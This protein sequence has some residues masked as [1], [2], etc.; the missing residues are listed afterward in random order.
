MPWTKLLADGY[1]LSKD[2]SAAG[3][4]KRKGRVLTYSAALREAL[5][6]ALKIDK[7]VFVMGEGV[8]DAGG[9]FGTTRGL[10]RLF[11][12]RRV[13][14]LPLAE[15]GFTGFA[16][17]AAITG[18]RP[19]IVHMRMDFML[20]SMDQIINHA[21]KW[22]YMFGGEQN[23]PLTI[24]C[25]IGRGWGSGAQHSQ[26]LEG[27]FMSIPGLKVVCPSNPYDA[28]GFLLSSISSNDP[29]IFVEHRWLYSHKGVVP[30]KPYLIPFG[31]GDILIKGKDITILTYSLMVNEALWAAQE[32]NNHGIKAEVIDL[33]S[34]RP[35]EKRLIIES[36][37]KTGRVII[38]ALD[39]ETGGVS[40]EIAAI[41]AEGAFSSLKNPIRR[42]AL[43]DTPTPGSHLLESAFYKVKTDIVKAAIQMCKSG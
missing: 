1:A 16:V 8:D 10:H 6:Q 39:W 42:I 23:V 29:V 9:I 18:M 4:K 2:E 36:A 33:R 41:A 26:S 25:I 27:L 35:L 11:G 13:F 40:S 31:K 28:K 34:L 17:G 14:D 21:A 32:L 12:K 38:A 22:R 43:P 3:L 15:N 19:V 37:K 30:L 24:R 7:R 5:S 20:L